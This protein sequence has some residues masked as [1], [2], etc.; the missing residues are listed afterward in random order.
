MKRIELHPS[1]YLAW[2]IANVEA[3]LSGSA[4][5]EPIHFLLA[6]LIIIDG[7]FEEVANAM[8]LSPQTIRGIF[9]LAADCR[10]VLKLSDDE[11]TKGRRALRRFLHEN[12]EADEITTLHRSGESR[13]IFQRAGRRTIAGANDELT[14]VHL[15][16]EILE[17]M[18][19]AAKP[20]FKLEP[21]PT[22]K[23]VDEWPDYIVDD[24]GH[25]K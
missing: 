18:P 23:S 19:S 11:I 5:I 9:D 16:E 10:S 24:S 3:C 17:H 2:N 1:V 7:V 4:R 12:A 8:N 21:T 13:Y 14:L 22:L 20:F 6:T 25:L 15:L